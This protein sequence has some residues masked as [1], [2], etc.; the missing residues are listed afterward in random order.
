MESKNLIVT[1]I[2]LLVFFCGQFL[3]AEK[4]CGYSIYLNIDTP[5]PCPKAHKGTLVWSKTICQNEARWLKVHFSK[6]LLND[7]DYVALIDKSGLV[8]MQIKGSDVSDEKKPKF[9]VKKNGTK[10]VSFWGPAVA[11]DSLKIELHRTSNKH[12]S[13]GFTIDEVG[14][15]FEAFPEENLASIM[16]ICG[17]NNL[18]H[19]VCYS[20]YE[21][22]DRGQAVGR[23]LY[24][25]NG[26]WYKGNGFLLSCDNTS[27]FLTTYC[28][29]YNQ[30]IVDTLEVAFDYQYP[31][32]AGT[33]PI[34]PTVY[35]G[36]ELIDTSS[37]YNYCLLTLENNPED[38]FT[39]LVPLSR[40]PY[41]NECLYIVQHPDGDP[42][43]IS[44][45]NVS[46]TGG[47]GSY[48]YH[49]ADTPY[50]GSLGS[51]ILTDDGNDYI[52][53]KVL[54]FDD[55]GNC[56]NWAIKMSKIYNAV[57]NYINCD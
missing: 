46:Y 24:S 25:K 43:M 36:D 6:F 49:Y 30:D 56:P 8:I 51:P 20:G 52:L 37:E 16:C 54:G 15:G 38:N 28:Q 42:K 17:T 31:T 5:H 22:Y 13:W 40:N 11:G 39:P 3:G 26:N 23:M 4:E 29:I 50:N 32:C 53:D 10:K 34:S 35:F 21:P 41:M 48:F 57:K 7:D 19:I 27:H 47:S 18:Q 14:V 12:N 33:G 55:G 9:K 44:F 2:V 1:I 45:G